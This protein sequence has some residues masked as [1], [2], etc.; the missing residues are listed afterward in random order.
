M[1]INDANCKPF[2]KR[3]KVIKLWIITLQIQLKKQRKQINSQDN[4]LTLTISCGKRSCLIRNKKTKTIIIIIK[5]KR[6]GD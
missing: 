3:R 4:L 2:E 1:E 5:G 6:K